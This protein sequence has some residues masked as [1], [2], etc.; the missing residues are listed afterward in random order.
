LYDVVILISRHDSDDGGPVASH[1]VYGERHLAPVD[2]DVGFRLEPAGQSAAGSVWNAVDEVA[3]EQPLVLVAA[4]RDDAI[5]S[6]GRI[7]RILRT[8][9]SCGPKESL[10]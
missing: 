2:V 4:E 10:L 9:L 3:E 6:L 5:E 8:R 1:V 7:T